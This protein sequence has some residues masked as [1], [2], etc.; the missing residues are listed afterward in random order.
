M[1]KRCQFIYGAH[2]CGRAAKVRLQ[3]NVPGHGWGHRIGPYCANHAAY[4]AS[5][6][7]E[8]DAVETREVPLA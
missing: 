6:M 1:S 5:L 2:L 4:K 8:H 3:I 7:A